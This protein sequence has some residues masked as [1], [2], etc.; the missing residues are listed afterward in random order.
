MLL[1]LILV[2]VLALA[3]PATPAGACDTAP[4]MAIAGHQ[5]LGMDHS[6]DHR[7]PMPAQH[8]CIGCVPLGDRDGARVA[9]P[10]VLAAPAPV[11]VIS[12]LRLLPAEAP[13]PPPPRIA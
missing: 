6:M 12:T 1:R 7:A 2:L 8:L 10:L 5:M 9:P 11:A 4:P 3:A 13:T